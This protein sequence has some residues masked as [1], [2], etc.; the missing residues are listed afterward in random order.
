VADLSNGDVIASAVVEAKLRCTGL[1]RLHSLAHFCAGIALVL[2]SVTCATANDSAVELAV[3]GITFTQS[4]DVSMEEEVLTITPDTVTVRYRFMNNAPSPVTLTVGFPL[5]DIDLSDTD[6]LYAIPGADP[7]NFVEFRTKVDGKPIKFDVV[8]RAKLGTKD[9]TAAVRGAGLPVL[10]LGSDAQRHLATLSPDIQAKLVQD[11]LLVPWGTTETGAQLFGPAW[12]VSTSF[13]RKQVFPANQEVVVEHRYK[14]SLGA[15]QDTILRK[16]LRGTD[17]MAESI[18][19]Y[20]REYCLPGDFFTG[21]D[22]LAGSDPANTKKLQERRIDYVLRTGANWAGPIKSFRL[23]VDKG[24]V[25]R[26]VS[27]CFDNVKKVSPTAF[28]ASAENFVPTRNLK[29]LLIGRY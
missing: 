21:L 25:D 1:P 11:G 20:R 16:A 26:L 23:V 8:Q 6:T 14:A 15:S 3:G 13:T 5:P 4:Q 2:L 24:R 17:G 10:L 19:R 28:E 27:F 9:V 22:K 18:E 7:V 12:S 29:I